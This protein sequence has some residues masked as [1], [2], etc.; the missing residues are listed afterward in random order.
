MKKKLN[1]L[2]VDDHPVIIEA[3]SN[4]LLSGNLGD[5][6]NFTFDSAKDCDSAI[7]KINNSAKS[8]HFD[9]LFLDVKLPPSSN[10][11]IISGEDLAIY[12]K[13]MLPKAKIIMLTMFNESFRIQN[14][15]NQ[16]NPD[17]LLIKDG[18]T[19][20]ELT[21]AFTAVL[22]DPPYYSPTVIKHFRKQSVNTGA[23]SLDDVNRK[24]IFYLSQGVKTKDLINYIFLSLSAIEKRKAYIK[25]LLECTDKS[26]EDL[27]L[28]AK[29]RGLI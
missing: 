14:I 9:V 20:A 27:I 4:I 13:K 29:K 8:E 19:S 6:Y 23:S 7:N 26:D 28:V 2:I 11:K 17:G 10:G 3:C 12:S 24:I 22:N 5:V 15:L 1:I 16:V 21:N 18:L 25:E